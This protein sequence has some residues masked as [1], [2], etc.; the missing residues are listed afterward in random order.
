MNETYSSCYLGVF[1]D[2][3]NW[4]IR[5]MPAAGERISL[6]IGVSWGSR[7]TGISFANRCV[8]DCC[9]C[10]CCCCAAMVEFMTD[11]DDDV[12]E[13]LSSS[14]FVFSLRSCSTRTNFCQSSAR[15]WP[16]SSLTS[17]MLILPWSSP[18]AI[19]KPLCDQRS[20]L[21]AGEPSTVMDALGNSVSFIRFQRS[22]RP[23]PSTHAYTA[24]CTGDHATS[25]T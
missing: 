18:T 21:S 10:C 25:Y 24:G 12:A 2:D 15:T 23:L 5:L 17:N 8:P 6:L 22:K 7:L 4:D 11:G 3:L 13:P 19:C 20:L 14:S 9:C 1:G 16:Y